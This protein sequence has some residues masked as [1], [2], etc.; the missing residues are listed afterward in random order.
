MIIAAW[1]VFPP[2]AVTN[3]HFQMLLLVVH[4]T[5][6]SDFA[7][8][9]NQEIIHLLRDHLSKIHFHPNF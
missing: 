9:D 7:T 5:L 1:I 3:I 4:N 8:S 6:H 2:A